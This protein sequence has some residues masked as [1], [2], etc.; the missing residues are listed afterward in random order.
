MN[1][2]VYELKHNLDRF[3]LDGIEEFGDGYLETKFSNWNEIDSAFFAAIKIDL[4]GTEGVI[5]RE[6]RSS[7]LLKITKAQMPANLI[8]TGFDDLFEYT[9]Y[10]YLSGTEYWPV[11]SK[12]MLNVLLSVGDFSHQIIPVI[13]KNVDS[14]LPT[15]D[16]QS[17]LTANNN[18]F[19]ITQLL[20]YSELFDRDKSDYIIEKRANSFGETLELIKIN[21]MVFKEPGKGFPPI[22]RIEK[23]EV[24]LYVSAEAKEALEK[25]NI[26][27]LTFS[28]FNIESS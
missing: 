25:A 23:R 24:R 11:M 8:F 14:L 2:K 18:D 20:E 26:K 3:Q 21:K 17:I 1:Q 7:N 15:H 16:G 13:F 19:V 9:D 22:F 28:S 12:R 10:P 4:C 27:G 6:K 5:I